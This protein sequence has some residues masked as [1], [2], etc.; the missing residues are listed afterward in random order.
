MQLKTARNLWALLQNASTAA[1]TTQLTFQDAPVISNNYNITNGQLL[2]TYIKCVPQNPPHRHLDTSN[3]IFQCCKPLTLRPAH[4]I[5][6]LT[7][8]PGCR[9]LRTNNLLVPH[10][11]P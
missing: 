10:F 11:T 8:Q 4:H 3:H 2:N 9:T 7:L 6:G 5:L 1:A